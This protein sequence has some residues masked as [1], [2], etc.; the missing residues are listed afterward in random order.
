MKTELAVLGRHISVASRSRRRW[1]VALTY[2]GFAAFIVAFV[3]FSGY[4][5]LTAGFMVFAV[6]CGLVFSSIA[7]SRYD[8]VDERDSRRRDHAHFVAYWQLSKF[9]LLALF[10]NYFR[11]PNPITP[12][13]APAL[14]TFLVQLPVTLLVVTG[15]LYAT[16]PQAILMWTEPDM[17]ADQPT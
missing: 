5:T 13:V 2:V 8:P 7:G 3:W 14:R 17:D 9:L 1:V 10:A 15:V 6:A 11:G 16:L 12:L 4:G